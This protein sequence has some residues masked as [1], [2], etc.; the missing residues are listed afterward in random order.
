MIREITLRNFYS[1]REENKIS[2]SVTHKAPCTDAYVDSANN[3]RLTKILACFGPNASG[4]TNLLKVLPF[5]GWFVNDSFSLK[6]DEEIP[7]KNF[8]F[9]KDNSEPTEIKITFDHQGMT[10]RYEAIL[11]AVQVL[12]EGLFVYDK[13]GFKYLF[14]R[15]WSESK[16]SY[17]FSAKDFGNTK[18]LSELVKKRKN[19]SAL[20]IAVQYEHQESKDIVGYF[21]NMGTNLGRKAKDL[22]EF[23]DFLLLQLMN[24]AEYFK[25]NSHHLERVNRI[26]GKFDLGL[27]SVE[28]DIIEG[29]SPHMYFPIG[30]HIGKDGSEHKL[31]FQ[32]ESHGTQQLYVLLRLILPVL[33]TGGIA[34]ID[35][36]END[37]HPHMVRPLIDLF[38]SRS[39]NPKNA[40]LLFTSHSTEIM[41]YLDKYQVLL[42]EKD[43]YGCSEVIRLDE[44]KGI[45]SDDNIYA[46]YDA[47]AYGAIPNI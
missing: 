21:S 25:N 8:L 4:K 17:S 3:A 34:V 18:A 20:S 2:F 27:K 37:L 1:F 30:V 39:T 31:N 16:S 38:V 9:E 40:Q 26:L 13:A 46:K 45:R 29:S 15:A 23:Q 11:N 44:I 22:Y 28:T 24:S 19:A 5:V 35:E 33:E 42:V 14:K 36:L 6:P 7:L 43:E 41:K 47:G 10:Y 32:S 12:K